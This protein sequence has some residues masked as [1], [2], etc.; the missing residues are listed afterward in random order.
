[1]IKGL[2]KRNNE[3][4]NAFMYAK[5]ADCP[6]PIVE[7]PDVIMKTPPN[8][9]SSKMIVERPSPIKKPL[10]SL[11]SRNSLGRSRA[12]LSLE[13]NKENEAGLRHQRP[14]R[15]PVLSKIQD[16][17]KQTEAP[18]G[19]ESSERKGNQETSYYERVVEP[20]E[21]E[22]G[23]TLDLD[24][25]LEVDYGRVIENEIFD[26]QP[27]F[28]G[29]L[30]NTEIRRAL[31]AKMVDWMI[32]VLGN[33][34]TTTSHQTF[35]LAVSIMDLYFKYAPRRIRESDLH[36]VGIASMFLA[37]KYED[38][39]HIPLEDFV[40]RVG[41][42]KFS[43][44]DIKTVEWEIL[45]ALD[46]N[47]SFPTVLTYLERLIYKNFHEDSNNMLKNIKDAAI[48]ILKMCM[49]DAPFMD[50]S[51]LTLALAV[52]CY[53][54]KCYF[55]S[56]SEENSKNGNPIDLKTQESCLVIYIYKNE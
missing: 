33:Y 32:E 36:L 29:C 20:I 15:V 38:V 35:F 16:H 1:M 51:P 12:Q 44:E 30:K 13:T 41:H 17:E 4:N 50:Y 56:L 21:I 2:L 6:Q 47:V 31:R 14:P 39:Y 3:A 9:G 26:H 37:S 55:F 10:E 22:L 46:Y 48:Q 28:S 7:N 5:R 49:H 45:I 53:C 54:I 24:L 34:H 8:K 23:P 19:T 11:D 52:L 40:Q 42:D 27:D 43:A 25:L 18:D